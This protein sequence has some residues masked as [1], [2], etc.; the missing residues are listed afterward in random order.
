[1]LVDFEGCVTLFGRL[2]TMS[3]TRKVTS[4]DDGYDLY[5]M[6]VKYDYDLDRIIGRGI[7]DDATMM[8]AIAKEAV[9]F[10][11]IKVD[12]PDF[13]C[14]AFTMEGPTGTVM[15]RNYDFKHNTSCMLVRCN[16]K[17]GYSSVG[18]AALNNINADR[19]DSL[20][21]KLTA[22]SS[23][24]IC[25]D[26]INKKGVSVAVLTLDSAPTFHDS[27]KPRISTSLAI[28]LVLDRAASSEE[29][30]EL[31][32]GYDMFAANGRDYHFYITDSKGKG[33]AV[34][35]DCDSETRD[36]TVTESDAMTNFF[37]MHMDKVVAVGKNGHY[38]HGKD[39]YDTVKEILSRKTD[40]TLADAWEALRSS[41]QEPD[42]D[43]PT[44]NTQWSVLFDNA[45][46]RADFVLRR[47][48]ENIYRYELESGLLEHSTEQF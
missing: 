5:M 11:S 19:L 17:N 18:F 28:R 44:S 3:T 43:I 13:G 24:F 25:L 14:T 46:G 1:M 9:P 35:Y 2:R 10:A 32:R 21:K 37:L 26:G 30:V 8:R 31:L 12:L 4:R 39:R 45:A 22:L 47:N 29:A 16:P 34:E 27:G 41:S 15:G 40:H 6:E 7:K 48:W 38:G 23:P 20:S 33:Y 36:L 42:P